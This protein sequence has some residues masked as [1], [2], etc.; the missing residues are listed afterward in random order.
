MKKTLLCSLLFIEVVQAGTRTTSPKTI[1]KEK[2]VAKTTRSMDGFF[3]GLGLQY[4]RSNKDIK[5][6]DGVDADNKPISVDTEIAHRRSGQPGAT[7]LLGYGKTFREFYLGGEALLD[8]NKSSK[9]D[10]TYG[11]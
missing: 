9:V 11:K 8:V 2:K 7:L 3:V 5:A 6:T 10:G 4:T 1:T